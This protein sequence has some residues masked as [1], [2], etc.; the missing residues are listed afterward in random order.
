MVQSK[1]FIAISFTPASFWKRVYSNLI[2]YIGP[3]LVCLYAL[4]NPYLAFLVLDWVIVVLMLGVGSLL[5]FV[6]WFVS[7]K[8]LGNTLGRQWVGV[9]IIDQDGNMPSLLKLALRE[10]LKIISLC[11]PLIIGIFWVILDKRN[12]SWYDKVTK[13]YV[14]KC[15]DAITVFAEETG[16][17]KK[18][19]TEEPVKYRGDSDIV[20]NQSYPPPSVLSIR[21]ETPEMTTKYMG[22]WIR[23]S[24]GLVDFIL[25]II[26][27]FVF[28]FLLVFSG[29]FF[30]NESTWRLMVTSEQSPF[31]LFIVWPMLWVT[32][33]CLL[34][35]LK[36]QTLGK[37]LFRMKVVNSKDEKSGLIRAIMREILGKLVSSMGLGI[38]FF[39]IAYNVEKRGWHDKIAG[40]YVIKA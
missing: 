27:S 3:L 15:P 2:D 35:G 34:T 13:T 10:F 26:F 12:Q 30:P 40:T 31:L 11:T 6:M 22:F 14:V 5:A 24:A 8:R 28:Y 20:S 29:I 1:D 21:Q 18:Q 32:Y 33:Y 36:G 16:Q 7:M 17:G 4:A 37:M 19:S 39:C 9:R 38:G 25:V 23:T